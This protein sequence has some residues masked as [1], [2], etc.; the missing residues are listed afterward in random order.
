MCGSFSNPHEIARALTMAAADKVVVNQAGK[1]VE[2]SNT[3]LGRQM[4]LVYKTIL[5]ELSRDD[6]ES[7]GDADTY[8]HSHHHDGHFHSHSHDHAHI[9]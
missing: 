1:S 9:H 8:D 5:A 6:E 7:P 4:A 3:E 2:E